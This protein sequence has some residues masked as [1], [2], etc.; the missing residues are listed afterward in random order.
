MISNDRRKA[1]LLGLLLGDACGVPFEFSS[2]D[3]LT[4]F[5]IGTVDFPP[6]L[7]AD[8]KRAHAG[9][10]QGTWSDDGAMAL[11]LL[12][13]L[14]ACQ[15]LDL[16]DLAKRFLN[17]RDNG[18]YAPDNCVFDIGN[19][20]RGGLHRIER[21]QD[22]RMA[23]ASGTLDNG[24]GALMRVLPLALWH[25][26]PAQT[27]CQMAMDQGLPT[28]GHLRSQVVCA[29]YCLWARNLLE[30]FDDGFDEALETLGKIYLD[31]G[32]RDAL[33][34]LEVILDG[35][36]REPRGT[37][38]V[39]DTLWS[40]RKAFT[41]GKDFRDVVE[42]AI[43]MGND[44]DTT[45]AVAGG[46]AGIRG[47]MKQLPKAWLDHLATHPSLDQAIETLSK[48]PEQAMTD[49]RGAHARCR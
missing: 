31:Q 42:R 45:A 27:L 25:T 48:L 22:P 41:E 35:K 44:T 46:L 6:N 29:L 47:G 11:A 30:G 19:Q 1:G 26:G 10:P 8:F 16:G 13:S 4:G 2:A 5:P 34:E 12:D 32:R 20:V 14:Q 3:T 15:A 39:L 28:H 36:E 43:L 37:G 23:G 7:P 49:R 33:E 24:N 18:A 21:G 40:A 9:A 38:Y 17:W